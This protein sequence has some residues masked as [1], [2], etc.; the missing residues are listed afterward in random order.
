MSD[1]VGRMYPKIFR[2]LLD[3]LDIDGNLQGLEQRMGLLEVGRWWPRGV[4][5][6][7]GGQKEA[8][9][10]PVSNRTWGIESRA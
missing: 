9:V 4:P 8:L 2:E 7:V 10:R 3:S 5:L 6:G 1:L